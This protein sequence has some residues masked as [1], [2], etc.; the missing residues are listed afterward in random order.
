MD[1]LLASSYRQF[2]CQRCFVSVAICRWCDRGDIYC[3]DKCSKAMRKETQNRA[4]RNYQNTPAGKLN[5]ASRER[6][7]KARQKL[8]RQ[9]KTEVSSCQSP[10]AEPEATDNGSEEERSNRKTVLAREERAAAAGEHLTSVTGAEQSGATDKV[11]GR[12]EKILPSQERSG[13]Q[14]LVTQQGTREHTGRDWLEEQRATSDMHCGRSDGLVQCCRCGRW[15][16]P[17]VRLG[18]WHG[19]RHFRKIRNGTIKRDRSGNSSPA[20][21]RKMEKGNDSQAAADSPFDS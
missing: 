7:Y 12:C 10:N 21:R 6:H 3:S 5:H 20:L 16:G 14:K 11:R 4:S 19:G 1:E 9:A 15:C 13:Y 8:V 18:P 2:Q 17:L